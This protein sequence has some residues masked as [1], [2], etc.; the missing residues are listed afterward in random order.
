MMRFAWATAVK[1]LA[2]RRR[3]PFALLGWFAIPVVMTLLVRLALGGAGGAQPR[4]LLLVADEDGSVASRLLAG[5]FGQGRL[6]EM[7]TVEQ[8]ERAAGRAR[9]DRGEAAAL[10]MIPKGFGSSFLENQ[11]AEVR[12]VTNPSQRILPGII[13]EALSILVEGGFYLQQVAGDQ[14]RMVTRQP[15]PQGFPD[16]GVAAVSVRFNRL[17]ARLRVWL[18]P[19]MLK[20]ETVVEQAAPAPRF[21]EAFFP[22]LLVLSVLFMAQGLGSDLWRERDLGTLRRMAATPQSVAAFL[23]GKTLAVAALL[24]VAGAATL[25]LGR[26]VAGV[27]AA[28]PVAALVWIAAAGSAFYLLLGLVQMAAGSARTANIFSSLLVFP[29]AMLGGSF[30]PFEFMPGTLARIGRWTPNGWVL[31]HLRGLLDGTATAGGLGAAAAVLAA[32]T[33]AAFWL[34]ARRLRTVAS[35]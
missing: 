14:L 23:A 8:V 32:V 16:A 24:A 31:A 19:P 3:D 33:A 4:G 26:A 25:L 28:R 22:G 21:E 5:A 30:F 18:D 20:V 11:P 17:A 27:A 2:R 1:D 15:G 35:C 12:L 7:I 6:G 9:M 29:F 34:T 13:E 10:L